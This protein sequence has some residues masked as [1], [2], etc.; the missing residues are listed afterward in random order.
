MGSALAGYGSDDDGPKEARAPS[1]VGLRL[2]HATSEGAA[3]LGPALE[4]ELDGAAVF[5]APSVVVESAV[6]GDSFD[7][8]T[9]ERLPRRR[10]RSLPGTDYG[11]GSRGG[12][13]GGASAGQL[14]CVEIVSRIA[15]R[16]MLTPAIV[17]VGLPLLIGVALRLYAT[18][19]TVI[20]SAEAL[21]ALLLVATIAGALGSLL[22]TNAGSAWDNAKKY[23]ETGAHGGRYV[24]DSS[25]LLAPSLAGADGARP[26]HSTERGSAGSLGLMG[27]VSRGA[28]GAGEIDNPTYVAAVI[29]DT[30][31]DPLKGAVAPATQALVTTLA[32]LALVFLPFFL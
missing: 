14:A 12:A 2:A 16:G 10:G 23:I 26:G 4:P 28:L 27:E 8:P 31:G 1:G 7:A 25:P 6:E 3:Y 5:R 29:G 9:G 32:A 13:G 20:A 21:V 30:I 24:L 11:P 15:L 18:E 17:G 19:D 22:F